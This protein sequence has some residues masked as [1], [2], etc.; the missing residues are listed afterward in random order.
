M[1]MSSKCLFKDMC[2][3]VGTPKCSPLCPAFTFMHGEYGDKGLWRTR[4]VPSKYEAC[5][6]SNLPKLSPATTDATIRRY[7]G[8][9]MKHVPNGTGLF[10]YSKPTPSN[11][12]GTGNGKT[13]TAITI[14]NEY[15]IARAYQHMRGENRL[16]SKRNPSLFVKSS[17]LQNVYNAQFR[18]TSEMQQQASTKYYNLKQ[19]M[20]TAELLVIDDIALR[21]G[22]EAFVNELYEVIDHRAV[23]ELATI[24]TS[25]I[26]LEELGAIYGDRIV[27]RIDGMSVQIAFDGKDNRKKI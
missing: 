20:L 26:P 5:R 25:N 19:A 15:T 6:G 11:K 22:T 3:K 14:L 23:E 24:F 17:D 10:L 13:T 12:F 16:T 9:V 2:S 1:D 7:I 18:G 8:A 21:S 4:N 27:S